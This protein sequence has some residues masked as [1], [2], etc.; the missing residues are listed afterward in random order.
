MNPNEKMKKIIGKSAKQSSSSI[1]S[2]ALWCQIRAK[3]WTGVPLFLAVL[4]LPWVLLFTPYHLVVAIF[5]TRDAA[6]RFVCSERV[7]RQQ[8]W[9]LG[10][11]REGRLTKDLAQSWGERTRRRLCSR[12]RKGSCVF[13]ANSA[14]LS[15]TFPVFYFVHYFVQYWSINTKFIRL[16]LLQWEQHKKQYFLIEFFSPKCSSTGH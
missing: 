11:P 10:C 2:C 12:V 9:R 6:L 4:L 3:D 13:P 15:L 5:K 7:T 1:P 8:S 16:D 14:L